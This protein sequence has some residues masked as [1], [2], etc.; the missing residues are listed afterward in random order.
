MSDAQYPRDLA[1]Y[2]ANPP[3]VNWPGNAR[4]AVQFVIN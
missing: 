4:I 3:Q 1:G 2:G